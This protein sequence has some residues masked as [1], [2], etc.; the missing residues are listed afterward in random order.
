[1]SQRSLEV[2][3]E[4][5][6]RLTQAHGLLGYNAGFAEARGRATFDQYQRDLVWRLLGDV[7]IGSHSTVLDVGCGIGGPSGWIYE[8]YHPARLI[9]IEYCPSSVRTAERRWS[10]KARRPIFLQGDAHFLP[11]PD[12][13][14]DVIFNLESALHYADKRKFISE[15]LRTLKP[16]GVLCL[17]DITTRYKRTFAVSGLLNLVSSQFSTHARLWNS[18]DY[19]ATFDSLGF[20]LIRHEQVTR[21]S[22]DSLADGL[23]DVSRAGWSAARGFRGRF[24]Y[25]AIMEKLL[26]RKWLDY[27]LFALKKPRAVGS[28]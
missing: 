24:F 9:G 13:S 10:G 11:V 25:L 8:R 2:F 22:A 14:V 19:L 12:R 5:N 27:D 26:R 17:G 7:D 16:G 23:K 1:M 4:P 3:Y 15:C 18:A 21:Q 6:L 20:Q 28:G